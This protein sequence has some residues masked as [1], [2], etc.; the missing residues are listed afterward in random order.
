MIAADRGYNHAVVNLGNV[1]FLDQDFE[2]SLGYYKKGLERDSANNVALLGAARCYY[3]LDEFMRSD[4]LYAE[5][6]TRD[7][8]LGKRYSYLGSFIDT[9][10]RAW[11]LAE[12]LHTTTWSLPKNLDHSQ[13]TG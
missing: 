11:S 8:A 2:G 1:A 9:E 12:R 4:T 10:G 6:G 7:D 13:D 5:L 3:E